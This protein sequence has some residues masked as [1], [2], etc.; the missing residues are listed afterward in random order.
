[1]TS[2]YNINEYSCEQ[3]FDILNN[4][5]SNELPKK[6][7]ILTKIGN[8]VAFNLV[9]FSINSENQSSVKFND[10][11][12]LTTEKYNVEHEEAK[13]K[14]SFFKM[15]LNPNSSFE[16]GLYFEGK[17]L[18]ST[19]KSVF[20][21]FLNKYLANYFSYENR[22]LLF[23]LSSV[24][25]TPTI[26]P[27]A[28]DD[29]TS[30]DLVI[31]NA[32]V[33]SH[34]NKATVK[35]DLWIES[36]RKYSLG[37]YSDL[38]VIDFLSNLEDNK[39][40]ADF[41]FNG[42]LTS[43]STQAF[44][45]VRKYAKKLLK[46]LSLSD[47]TVEDKD[48]LLK[49]L[50]K[51][52]NDI[53]KEWVKQDIEGRDVVLNTVN[54][55][56]IE[57]D[58]GK[59]ELI[60]DTYF[61]FNETFTTEDPNYLNKL[62]II[63]ALGN[64]DYKLSGGVYLQGKLETGKHAKY[65]CEKFLKNFIIKKYFRIED[66]N[67]IFDYLPKEPSTGYPLYTPIKS[68]DGKMA[69]FCAV[70][71]SVID[72]N[73]QSNTSSNINFVV[74]E[75]TFFD[76]KNENDKLKIDVLFKT[77]SSKYRVLGMYYKGMLLPSRLLDKTKDSFTRTLVR[78]NFYLEDKNFI[79][80]K[81]LK[82]PNIKLPVYW[83]QYNEKGKR[84][85]ISVI[86]CNFAGKFVDFHIFENE[87]LDLSNS[88]DLFRYK[89]LRNIV[90]HNGKIQ[91]G[92]YYRGNLLFGKYNN[93]YE[94][95]RLR[96]LEAAV[97]HAVYSNAAVDRINKKFTIDDEKKL[98]EY[99]NIIRRRVDSI[100]KLPYKISGVKSLFGYFDEENKFVS[101][102]AK[103]NPDL[104]VE[105]LEAAILNDSSEGFYVRGNLIT[106]YKKAK[107]TKKQIHKI[108]QYL[109]KEIHIDCLDIDRSIE[110]RKKAIV[111]VKQEFD[112]PFDRKTKM[113]KYWPQT[114]KDGRE[115]ILSCVNLDVFFHVGSYT[116]KAAQNI[117]FNVYRGETFGLVGESGS[118]KT[119]ISRAILRLNKATNG[120]IYF[121][122]KLI[123]SK[124]MNAHDKKDL[125]S[126]IQ[127]IFQDPA[128]SLNERANV[129]YIISEGLNSFDIGE[130]RPER[131]EIV[132]NMLEKVG[133]LPEHMCRFPHE[134]SGGQ[135]QRI[136][137][138]RALV[139][140]PELVLADEPIS[141][142]DVSI[143]A[144]V[145]N[146]LK[147]LQREQKLTYIFVAHDLSIIR[148]ISD[149]VAVM[150]QGHIVEIGSAE[151]IYNNPTHPYTRS[152]LTAIPQPDPDSEKTR[153]RKK[154]EK[155]SID[156]NRCEFMTV[157]KGH[158]VL[159]D[160]DLFAKWTKK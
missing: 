27:L 68:K 150:H 16:G 50:A 119:T 5:P 80:S 91:G 148:Y 52:P 86:N 25:G 99:V 102:N 47:S 35:K 31:R 93:R 153:I 143:R 126:K 122:G 92:L 44:S 95:R 156:Y 13:E 45:K 110:R 142:L 42:F 61:L 24:D 72:I 22:D 43:P 94:H 29:G 90:K 30:F 33:Y 101:I 78:K 69:T 19:K 138:A 66:M 149:R 155:G 38:E 41:Y 14:L 159:A 144:Q 62:K 53:L 134:F 28:S 12:F 77:L 88:E 71:S 76:T 20:L 154:Y 84:A 109:N 40:K 118:G 157:E 98:I 97:G 135:R 133:L 145:L 115:V 32:E 6:W 139:V 56:I 146:L 111:E 113:P 39:D 96:D 15:V 8:K 67:V 9:N 18:P 112:I 160:K 75:E 136:G 87:P 37:L 158:S 54:L 104:V 3:K 107:Y 105:K 60:P 10:L 48:I 152:L 51:K 63:R 34:V 1:M 132:Q 73:N 74:F 83:P 55:V 59:E 100:S 82:D 81:F 49:Y 130:N 26:C 114:D 128:A 131:I 117:S 121:K 21:K 36:D 147:D 7:P 23:D 120:A 2:K 46:D 137:I 70:K 151:N 89:V 124:T 108:S 79:I 17:L 129:E 58:S 125:K 127:M 123:S 57:K 4:F 85:V 141:A 116:V 103:K 65:F 106:V 140:N 11:I 64:D